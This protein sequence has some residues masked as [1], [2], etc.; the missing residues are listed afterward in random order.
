MWSLISIV[1]SGDNDAS[2]TGPD[3][4]IAMDEDSNDAMK[5]GAGQGSSSKAEGKGETTWIELFS[6]IYF[7]YC[8]WLVLSETSIENEK[9]V[10]M[11]ALEIS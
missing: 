5:D 2:K 3:S 8:S 7:G 1:W 10:E 9:L 4:P 6:L 11:V